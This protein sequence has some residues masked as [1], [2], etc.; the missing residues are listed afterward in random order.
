MCDEDLLDVELKIKTGKH[1]L[2]ISKHFYGGKKVSEKV[3]LRILEKATIANL[4]GSNTVRLAEKNGF[5]TS[6]NIITIDGTPHAQFVKI[7]QT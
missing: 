4:M 6:E 2:K 1:K 7:V 3:A 5:I